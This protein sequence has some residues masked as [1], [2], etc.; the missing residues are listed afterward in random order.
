[1]ACVFAWKRSS[2][3]N[4][5]QFE[6]ATMAQLMELVGRIYSRG[7]TDDEVLEEARAF[8]EVS[9]LRAWVKEDLEFCWEVEAE[10]VEK[11]QQDYQ[12]EL[13]RLDQRL[14]MVQQYRVQDEDA[15]KLEEMRAQLEAEHLRRVREIRQV[16]LAPCPGC[17]GAVMAPPAGPSLFETPVVSGVPVRVEEELVPGETYTPEE[18][19][20]PEELHILETPEEALT[21]YQES[22]VA[23]SLVEEAPDFQGGPGD[24]F[25]SP[26]EGGDV[27]DAGVEDVSV[28]GMAAGNANIT[29]VGVS[30]TLADGPLM[31]PVVCDSRPIPVQE[32]LSGAGQGPYEREVAASPNPSGREVVGRPRAS[33][34]R[35]TGRPKLYGRE[36]PGRPKLY[37]REVTGR[38]KLSGRKVAG[39]LKP[40]VG[41]GSQFSE[42]SS[43]PWV[44]R[45]SEV[46]SFPYVGLR[47]VSAGPWEGRMYASQGLHA[48]KCS[49]RAP[50]VW[51][52][53]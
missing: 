13:G 46:S 18:V 36:V 41:M 12:R 37:A 16:C 48:R 31:V 14:Y 39:S 8:T 25:M 7:C 2:N 38:L 35:L 40:P 17:N 21:E 32:I 23:V 19:H 10:L 11:E 44:G 1:M 42:A 5:E 51:A 34:G 4:E 29:D 33:G 52:V 3:P 6:K 43:S 9:D 20:M 53:P 49:G 15:D 28:G 50:R 45:Y 22:R 47:S 24:T 30:A 26:S 27:D